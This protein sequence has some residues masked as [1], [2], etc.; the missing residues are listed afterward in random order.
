[1]SSTKPTPLEALTAQLTEIIGSL[2]LE[3][4]VDALNSVRVALHSV[5]PFQEPVDL[6]LWIPKERVQG[7][8]DYRNPNFVAK[9]EMGLLEH[10]MLKNGVGMPVVTHATTDEEGHE[11]DIVV[12]GMHRR[13]LGASHPELCERLH[14]Y[15]PV[16]RLPVD[17]ADLKG[18]IAATIEYNR[19]RGEHAVDV[20]SDLVRMLYVAGWT[21][22][23]I[24]A[25]LGMQPDEVLRLKQITGLAALFAD[26][27][28]SEA[29]EPE[30]TV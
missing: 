24:Q 4:R 26:R 13:R 16:T 28:F 21:D 25:E 12:D 6:V 9:P 11:V 10:S 18:R 8:D 15:L 3:N 29:W 7:Y 19:A 14:G 23:Q 20:M 22:E 17:R 1:M 30:E 2:P 27:E 5:S